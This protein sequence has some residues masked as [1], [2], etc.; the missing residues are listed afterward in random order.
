MADNNDPKEVV[1]L[2]Q[3]G[4]IV[5]AGIS[6]VCAVLHAF[7]PTLDEKTAM[8]LVVAIAALVIHQITKFKGFGSQGRARIIR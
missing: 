8:F 2:N 6:V 7:F 4:L 5:V 1:K 3:Y